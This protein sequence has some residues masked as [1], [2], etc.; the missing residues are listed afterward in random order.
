[1]KNLEQKFIKNAGKEIYNYA[2]VINRNGSRYFSIFLS[3]APSKKYEDI[4][5]KYIKNQINPLLT[6]INED[7]TFNDLIENQK[8]MVD[9]L[10]KFQKE[11]DE[12]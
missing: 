1:M 12:I 3:I 2:F 7:M 4:I 6:I 5:W 11:I 10:N 9:I 8:K